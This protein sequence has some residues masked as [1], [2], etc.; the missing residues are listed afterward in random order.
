MLP[1]AGPRCT[2]FTPGSMA[3]PAT[4][5]RPRETVF[6]LPLFLDGMPLDGPGAAELLDPQF[7]RDQALFRVGVEADDRLRPLGAL[8]RP[9]FSNLHVAGS[10]QADWDYAAGQ[11]GLGA[12]LASGYW[13]GREAAAAIGSMRGTSDNG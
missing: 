4:G 6:D 9:I 13:A 2:W 10:I 8:G 1:S 3:S 12:A 7:A 5:G 11:G